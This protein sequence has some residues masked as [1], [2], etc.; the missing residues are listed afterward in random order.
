MRVQYDHYV[1]F[2]ICLCTYVGIAV[3]RG[4]EVAIPVLKS[5]NLG[6]SSLYF[7]DLQ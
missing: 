6:L 3:H 7:A 5:Y 1:T 4:S 2:H